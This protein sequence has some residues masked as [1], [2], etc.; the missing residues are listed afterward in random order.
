MANRTVLVWLLTGLA[1]YA[2]LPW[3]AIED[4]FWGLE[5][6]FDGYP[7]EPEY[8][9]LLF[10]MLGGEAPWLWPLGI[11]LAIAAAALFFQR[12]RPGYAVALLVGGG[13]G[14]AYA[15]LQ[16]F[17]IGIDGWE[18]QFLE[19]AFGPFGERQFGMGYGALLIAGGLF[20]LLTQAL[21]ARGAVN[22]DVFVVGSIGLIVAVVAVFIFFPVA[23][24]LISAVQDNNGAV[25]FDLF[26]SKL[27]NANIWGLYCL[28][29]GRGCGVAWNSFMLAVAVGIGSTLL[30]LAFALIVTR[31][32]F[33]YKKAIRALTV[34]PIITPPFVIG[35][36]LILLLGQSGAVTTFLDW[37][38]G[39]TPSRWLYG[40]TGVWLAQMLAFTPIAF[41][42]L[43]GVVQGVSPSMEE[44]AQTLRADGWTTFSTVSFPLMRPG[45]ANAFLLGFIESMADFGN[46]MVLGGNFDVLSTE[47]FFAIVGAQNDQ[48]RA[49]VLALVLLFFTLLAFYAQRR[50]LGG[51][52]YTTVTGKGD[53]GVHVALPQRLN[54]LVFGSAIPWALMTAV[55]YVMIMFGGFVETWGRNHT[56]TL[57]HYLDAF[58]VTQ[59]EHGL[60][61]SGGAWNSF[62]TTLTI[63]A[64]SAPL[65]AGLGLLAAYLLVR[66]RFFGK[67]AFEFGTMLSFAIPGTVIGVSYVLAFNVPPFELT[68]TGAILVISFIFRNMPVGVRAGIASMSQLDQSLDEA[69]LTLG[70]NSWTTVRRVIL[71]LLRPAIVAA[72]VYSFVRAMTAISAVIFL[73]SAEYDMA[74]SYILG[75]V[76]NNDYG[77]SIAY[78]SVL[79][80]VMF[81]AVVLVQ[82]A[83][84]ERKI[85]RRTE[86]DGAGPA[87]GGQAA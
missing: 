74:T 27:F 22:G 49:A 3:Y 35:L 81:A 13:G 84:G 33:R 25:A 70:A 12:D 44:A 45:L 37:A 79:I 38:F 50:W 85:G 1:G 24:I 60:V 75:R 52:S 46:P 36:A 40:F 6:A 61:W 16:G 34:L 26:A 56:L 73:V 30:G 15:L 53:A 67:N 58:A 28:Y 76:E 57:R 59:G 86:Q 63:S 17:A 72:L 77:I 47:I 32:G 39:I 43:I 48:G 66:Q 42:V 29:S 10:L 8:A 65:T 83:V 80:L 54:W 11:F 68:G 5:W 4:G 23:R 20:F 7:F 31:T 62:W 71:P 69:S 78:C 55:I 87:L 41:L 19:T 21:A 82:L 18:Y 64:V 2:L 14:F 9:P 51:K